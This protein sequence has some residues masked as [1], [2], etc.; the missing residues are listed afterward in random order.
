MVH[1]L[2]DGPLVDPERVSEAREEL[3]VPLSR[4]EFLF[5]CRVKRL[6]V[7][8]HLLE[9]AAGGLL[10]LETPVLEACDVSI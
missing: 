8:L 5:E 10:R 1:V 2:P 7:D 4:S 3:V 9:L 6:K